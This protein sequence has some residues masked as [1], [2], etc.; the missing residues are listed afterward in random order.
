MVVVEGKVHL[1]LW[2][3]SLVHSSKLFDGD[4]LFR[5]SDASMIDLMGIAF[6]HFR[7]IQVML[8]KAVLD[9]GTRQFEINIIRSTRLWASSIIGALSQ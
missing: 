9:L 1:R 2:R 8:F 5:N 7:I 3:D 6:V 4:S